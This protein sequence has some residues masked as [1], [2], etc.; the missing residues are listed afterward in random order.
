MLTEDSILHPRAEFSCVDCPPSLDSRAYLPADVYR[1]IAHGTGKP[2]AYRDSSIVAER[3]AGKS[4]DNGQRAGMSSSSA[5]RL[6]VMPSAQTRNGVRSYAGI[7]ICVPT[8]PYTAFFTLVSVC[9]IEIC[10]TLYS[11]V[12]FGERLPHRHL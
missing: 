10:R 6:R 11:F 12:Y 1:M 7:H 4:H 9:P 8:G 3:N 5:Y 2:Y